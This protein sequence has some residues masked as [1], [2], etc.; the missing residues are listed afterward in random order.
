MGRNIVMLLSEE[1]VWEQKT[2]DRWA[3]KIRW[4]GVSQAVVKIVMNPHVLSK[5][6]DWMSS[7]ASVCF[8]ERAFHCDFGYYSF[9]WIDLIVLNIYKAA[10]V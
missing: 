4:E 6:G 9:Y 2:E 3:K 8:L 7:W 1:Y 5:T 10:A